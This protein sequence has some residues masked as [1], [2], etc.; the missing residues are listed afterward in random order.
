MAP[1]NANSPKAPAA[2]A[3]TTTAAV[4][5]QSA[6]IVPATS[7]SNNNF[8]GDADVAN[9]N[10]AARF[11]NHLLTP[12]S[13][14]SSTVQ[15][16][17]NA[18]M[19]VLF[20]VWGMFLAAM[21]DEI[22]VWIFGVLIFGLTLSTN[23]FLTEVMKIKAESEEEERQKQLAAEGGDGAGG[24]GKGK[25]AKKIA[26]SPAATEE[27]ARQPAAAAATPAPVA[28]ASVRNRKAATAP[29]GQSAPV[30]NKATSSP[31]AAPR[32]S[33]KEN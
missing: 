13:A 9:M 8:F 6:D 11:I 24:A 2:A 32:R 29:D 33:K 30:G 19:I 27:A 17:F 20:V 1:K 22:H 21:P 26:A 16:A 7:T 31:P 5:A 12:G 23:W 15:M 28:E 10:F 14:L 18:I 25:K 3:P 4:V